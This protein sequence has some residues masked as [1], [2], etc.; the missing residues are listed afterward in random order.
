M[1]KFGDLLRPEGAFGT[2]R[3]VSQLFLLKE[4]KED[5]VWR[6]Y[7]LP[8][9]SD[10]P[11]NVL[12]IWQYSITEMVN[13]AIDHSNGM[14]V[15]LVINRNDRKT[16]IML[17]DDG[18]GIFRNIK[19]KCNLEDERQAVLELAKGK[20]TTDP[21]RHTGEGIFFTSRMVDEFEI[22]SGE[23]VYSHGVVGESDWITQREKPEMGTTLFMSLLNTSTRTVREVFDR[24][25]SE[26]D[27]Y[28]FTK[29]V[30]PV[31]F[32]KSGAENLVSRSQ[33][34]RLLSRL[35]R[36]NTVIFDFKD[37]GSIGQSFADEI[38]R[39]FERS[40]SSIKLVPINAV[41]EV[42]MMINRARTNRDS[43]NGGAK[44]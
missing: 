5:A 16:E 9:L 26:S 44:Q 39:V 20:L 34:K 4:L 36:F 42:E 32:A 7:A 33:A 29:T 1:A 19:D 37:V 14:N 24:F 22:F 11:E 43:T 25:A 21:E 13:N 28:G 38:F 15:S 40:H 23:V 2:D 12:H 8:I 10:L 3:K 27:D 6:D 17:D 30:V 41:P 35:D 31:R 18:I